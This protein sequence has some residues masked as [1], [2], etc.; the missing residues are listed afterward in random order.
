MQFLKDTYGG[1]FPQNIPDGTKRLRFEAPHSKVEG[2]ADYEVALFPD[3][4]IFAVVDLGRKKK[5]IMVDPED[6]TFTGYLAQAQE[7]L[8]TAQAEK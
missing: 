1:S 7:L 2:L 5:T 4:K 6:P 8:E 3:G